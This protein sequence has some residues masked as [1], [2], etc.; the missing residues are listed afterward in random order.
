MPD[1]YMPS[2]VLGMTDRTKIWIRKSLKYLEKM[3]VI[4]H[5]MEHINDWYE[6]DENVISQRA[7]RKLDL[8]YV[9]I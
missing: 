2:F 7:A 4:G 1:Q 5:E 6:R 9:P 3:F 8:A